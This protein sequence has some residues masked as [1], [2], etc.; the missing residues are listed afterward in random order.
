MCKQYVK[1]RSHRRLSKTVVPNLD[2]VSLWQG[3][4]Q[5]LHFLGL[6]LNQPGSKGLSHKCSHANFKNF[7]HPPCRTL[8]STFIMKEKRHK[9]LVTSFLKW[10]VIYWR[11]L[12]KVPFAKKFESVSRKVSNSF[13][14]LTIPMTQKVIVMQKN[15]LKVECDRFYLEVYIL[16]KCS[17]L[18]SS[19]W[20]HFLFRQQKVLGSNTMFC[21]F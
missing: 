3:C 12:Y 5:S 15:V 8:C 11:A 7:W 4:R 16:A 9:I 18:F 1:Y 19:V 6:L 13:S 21:G 17:Y 20:G 2:A 10:D 14:G